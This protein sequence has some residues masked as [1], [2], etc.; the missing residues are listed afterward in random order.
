[1]LQGTYSFYN[2]SIDEVK[3]SLEELPRHLSQILLS[4]AKA[5]P[6]DFGT[7]LRNSS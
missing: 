1:M 3:G 7:G 4:L 5:L 6:T 2:I